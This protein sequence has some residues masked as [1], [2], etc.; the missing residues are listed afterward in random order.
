MRFSLWWCPRFK[1]SWAWRRVNGQTITV[2]SQ[3]R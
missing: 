1:S 2:V 3:N